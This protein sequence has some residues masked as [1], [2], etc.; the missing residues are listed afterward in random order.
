MAI[1]RVEGVHVEAKGVCGHVVYCR[2]S[3]CKAVGMPTAWQVCLLYTLFIH[4]SKE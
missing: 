4:D 1:Q 3:M 2:N